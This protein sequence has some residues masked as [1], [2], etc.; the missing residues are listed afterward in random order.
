MAFQDVKHIFSS[1]PALHLLF[2]AWVVG[3]PIRPKAIHLCVCCRYQISETNFQS[4][5]YSRTI[6][7]LSK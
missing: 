6:E 5:A 2:P 4:P 7:Y 3:T 1:T